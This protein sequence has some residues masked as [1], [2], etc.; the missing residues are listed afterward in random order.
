MDSLVSFVPIFNAIQRAWMEYPPNSSRG[1]AHLKMLSLMRTLPSSYVSR[2]G[3]GRYVVMKEGLP[4]HLP[5][6]PTVALEFA[7][8]HKVQTD[9]LWDA[10][11]GLWCVADWA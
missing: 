7:T 5:N 10:G 3:D 9:V 8:M 4:L 6:R 11:L 1:E 2:H